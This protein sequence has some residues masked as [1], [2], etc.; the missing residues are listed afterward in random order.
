AMA[1]PGTRGWSRAGYRRSVRADSA[2][3]RERGTLS[4]GLRCPRALAIQSDAQRGR[5]GGPVWPELPWM[6]RRVDGGD[7]A[8]RIIQPDLDDHAECCHLDLQARPRPD[9]ALDVGTVSG[10]SR[11]RRAVRRKRLIQPVAVAVSSRLTPTNSSH[12]PEIMK[13]KLD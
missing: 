13:K 10:G 6:Q 5:R 2:Q 8:D 1:Q 4:R 9:L 11:L 3:A 12:D 7:G